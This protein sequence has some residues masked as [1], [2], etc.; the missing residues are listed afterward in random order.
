[1]VQ[2]ESARRRDAQLRGRAMSAMAT[3]TLAAAVAVVVMSVGD[4]GSPVSRGERVLLLQKA[5]TEKLEE[6]DKCDEAC[7]VALSFK[8]SEE[9]PA[10]PGSS[11]VRTAFKLAAPCEPD[12]AS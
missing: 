6:D 1:M 8:I 7:K 10:S 4:V 5:A 9:I 12:S 2:C 3:L 11:M